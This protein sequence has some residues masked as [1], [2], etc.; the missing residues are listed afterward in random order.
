MR[1]TQL[2]RKENCFVHRL[3]QACME[4]KGQDHMRQM[5]KDSA[6]GRAGEPENTANVFLETYY[7][8]A[9]ISSFACP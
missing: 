1:H 2:Q 5:I 3:L 9:S 4:V 7:N 8:L 6:A